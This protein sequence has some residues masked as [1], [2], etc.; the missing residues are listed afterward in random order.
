LIFKPLVGEMLL[1]PCERFFHDQLYRF[2]RIL[3]CI[4]V[5]PQGSLI[6]LDHLFQDVG[7]GHTRQVGSARGSCQRERETNNVMGGV[8]DD[9]LVE[10]A[11]L[12]GNACIRG[13]D[14]S[15]IARV[16]V[17]ANP[18]AGPSGNVPLFCASSHS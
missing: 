11:D 7:R 8:A 17:A 3:N 6:A 9:R 1:G 2:G 10:I 4:G 18:D 16:T 5:L 12:N 14:W 15:Q 13:G